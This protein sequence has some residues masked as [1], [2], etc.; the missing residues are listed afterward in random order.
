[1][2]RY[3]EE[4]GTFYIFEQGTHSAKVFK[5]DVLGSV[6]RREDTAMLGQQCLRVQ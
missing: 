1:M 6:C 3:T 5:E 4:E 2:T